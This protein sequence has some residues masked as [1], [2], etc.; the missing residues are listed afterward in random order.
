MIQSFDTLPDSSRVW[1]YQADRAFA[2]DEKILIETRVRNFLDKWQ[3]HGSDMVASFQLYFDQVVV[4]AADERHQNATG[5][6]ID[7]QFGVIKQLHEDLGID[8]FNRLNVGLVKDDKLIIAKLKDVKKALKTGELA[9]D[10]ILLDNT[11]QDLGA[12]RKNWQK[13]IA[14]SWLKP[15][16]QNVPA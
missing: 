2:P 3:A 9:S 8:F 15:F 10:T 13:P 5:C 6:S 12:F 14:E 7:A 11:V 16:I 1:I 4:I